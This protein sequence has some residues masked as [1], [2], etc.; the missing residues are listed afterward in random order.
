MEIAQVETPV[1]W[2]VLREKDGAL[3]SLKWG[4]EKRDLGRPTPLLARATRQL[5]DYF[6][7]KRHSFDLPLNPAGTAFQKRVWKSLVAIPYGETRPYGEVARLIK[8]APRAVGM[9][10]GKNPL[11]ILIPCH[12]V[13]ASNGALGGY[14]GGKGLETKAGLLELEQHRA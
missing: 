9:G 10:C 8:S 14:S 11:P 2:L 5:K 12:R 6:A 7:G 3:V 4:K 13:V 1:G